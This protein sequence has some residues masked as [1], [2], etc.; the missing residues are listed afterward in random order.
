MSVF[1]WLVK[2]IIKETYK[3]ILQIEI[4][5]T[6]DKKIFFLWLF[7]FSKLFQQTGSYLEKTL[8]WDVGERESK[9]EFHRFYNKKVLLKRDEWFMKIS[10]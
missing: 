1:E 6:N 10:P 4:S 8:R 7:A 3:K 5:L 9:I 2:G